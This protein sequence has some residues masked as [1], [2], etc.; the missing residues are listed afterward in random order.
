MRRLVYECFFVSDDVRVSD[1]C[2]Y[3]HLIECVLLLLVGEFLHAHLLQRVE[4]PIRDPLHMVHAAVGALTY[5]EDVMSAILNLP[6]LFII[7]KSFNDISVGAFFEEY[8]DYI[9][10]NKIK[11]RFN[12]ELIIYFKSLAKVLK[13][14]QK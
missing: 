7:S 10:I 3:A 13:N 14:K 8:I 1:G 5:I 4:V 11:V 9:F 2:E 12:N 6:S